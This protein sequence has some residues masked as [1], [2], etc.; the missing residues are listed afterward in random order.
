MSDFPAGARRVL[1]VAFHYPP[2]GA[3]SGLQRTL[4]FTR[5][6]RDYGWQ[7]ALVT[8]SKGAYESVSQAQLDTVPPDMPV[9]RA[10]APDAARHLALAGRYPA[11]LAVPDRWRLWRHTGLRAARHLA[12]SFRPD[13]L[14]STFPIPTAHAIAADLVRETGLP[15]VADMRDPMVEFEP[16]D[17][18]WY[19]RDSAVREARL[20]IESDVQRLATA[21]V[22]CTDGAR[23]IF[24]E[25]YGESAGPALQIVPNGYDEAAFSE[26][27]SAIGSQQ[28]RRDRFHAVHSGTVYPGSDRGPEALF[29]AIADLD[30]T[31]QLPAGFC[32]T[33][34]AAG[35]DDYLAELINEHGVS[36][37]I[38]LAPPVSYR[39]ALTEMLQAD[40]LVVLQGYSSNPA[41]PAKVYEYLR[42][43][44][45]IL[46][47]VHPD[48][49]TAALLH[50]LDVATCAA[51]DDPQAIAGALR[52]L[53]AQRDGSGSPELPNRLLARY[54]REQQ[55]GQLAR[56][57]AAAASG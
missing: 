38:E 45:P 43:K 17:R 42:A 47:L 40:A 6:L 37:F 49:D 27:E 19:P 53:F 30:R 23:R 28:A 12:R 15:W 32:L 16:V 24:A 35:H 13:V 22:F 54:S 26:A 39:D 48:G 46:G 14:W 11:F 36:Q 7:P 41:I 34:R 31:G 10:L 21:A 29:A 20:E 44:R 51:L 2:C 33:L 1:M 5:Y 8:A 4:A 50:D 9:R 3:S 56:I 55:T 57:L 52:H 18:V 25:R